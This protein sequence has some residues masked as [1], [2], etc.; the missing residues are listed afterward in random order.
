MKI[1]DLEEMSERYRVIRKAVYEE[2][3]LRDWLGNQRVKK[4]K[5]ENTMLQVELQD[6]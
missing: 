2:A 6:I 4:T 3:I 5:I 1:S